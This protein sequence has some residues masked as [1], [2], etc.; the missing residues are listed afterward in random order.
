MSEDKKRVRGNAEATVYVGNLAKDATEEELRS[1][2]EQR[3]GSVAKVVIIRDKE[4]QESKGYAFVEF[5][6]SIKTE[7][8]IKT[9]NRKEFKGKALHIKPYGASGP[10]QD[11]KEFRDSL[12]E[13]HQVMVRGISKKLSLKNAEKH[14]RDTFEKIGK[15]NN[16]RIPRS[17]DNKSEH[18]GY[19]FIEFHKEKHAARA[20]EQYHSKTHKL[21]CSFKMSREDYLNQKKEKKQKLAQ[22][23]EEDSEDENFEDVGTNKENTE[24]EE[25][26]QTPGELLETYSSEDDDNEDNLNEEESDDETEK[27]DDEENQEK[28]KRRYEDDLKRTIFIK[29]LPYDVDKEN[30]REIF[31][32]K[33]GP[34]QYVAP[35]PNRETG[36]SNG[37]AFLKFKFNDAMRKLLQDVELSSKLAAIEQQ[38]QDKRNKVNV[39]RPGEVEGLEIDGR[40]MI[41]SKA[42]SKEEA[43]DVNRRK[44]QERIK[45]Q[46]KRNLYLMME[47]YISKDSEVAKTIPEKHMQKI[48]ANYQAKKKKLENPIFHIS[49]TRLAVQNLP[50]TMNEAQLKELFLKYAAQETEHGTPHIKQ[51]KIVKEKDPNL[52]T[53]ELG[54]KGYGFVEFTK[55][56]HAL[57]ALREINN[58]PY[59]FKDEPGAEKRKRKR[60]G[61]VEINNNRRLIV[62][63]AIENTMKL[64]KLKQHMAN[65]SRTKEDKER[66]QRKLAIEAKT[67]S[68]RGKKRK[69]DQMNTN[70]SPKKKGNIKKR[71]K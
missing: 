2:F 59:I 42:I 28:Q 20:V 51:C 19:G 52:R 64:H 47:G 35:V 37:T 60:K 34:V 21:R 1:F 32:E 18:A 3:V 53:V 43:E 13:S 57:R 66:L 63:F 70:K 12:M 22:K 38:N 14:L 11:P 10:K 9:L 33:Y 8:A 36:L 61:E 31:E 50:K 30:I 48:E 71:R 49:K 62:E 7:E 44:K 65:S 67:K 55:H 4:S 69:Y 15:I 39:I 25:V 6:L 45:E 56:E 26:E 16:I 23:Q 29:N 40:K 58:N 5:M 24:E 27:Q 54:S 68:Q 46:D 17:K 41:I